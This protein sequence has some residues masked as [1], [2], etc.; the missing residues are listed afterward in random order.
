MPRHRTIRIAAAALVAT[1]AAAGLTGCGDVDAGSAAASAFEELLDGVP[2]VVDVDAS[3]SND[4]PWSGTASA[5]VLIDDAVTADHLGEIVDRIGGF[6]SE[7]SKRSGGATW[8]GVDV[9]VR[10]FTVAVLDRREDNA[11]QLELL[12]SL[13]AEGVPGG[14]LHL[15]PVGADGG[16][17]SSLTLEARPGEDFLDAYDLAGET[18]EATPA[19]ADAVLTGRSDDGDPIGSGADEATNATPGSPEQGEAARFSISS[20]DDDDPTA[21]G[22]P[23]G[24][25]A[26]YLA[27]AEQFAVIG[28]TLT[29]DTLDLRIANVDDVAAASALAT[30]SLPTDVSVEIQGGIVTW[31]D[32]VESP[33]M[34]P[35]VQAVGAVPGVTAID[36]SSDSLRLTVSDPA[37]G[38]AALDTLDTLPAASVVASLRIDGPV[39]AGAPDTF[40]VGGSRAEAAAQFALVEQGLASGSLVSFEGSADRL[41]LEFRNGDDTMLGAAIGLV[42]AG[43][44]P[45]TW[46][47]IEI[48]GEPGTWW[49]D[50]ADTVTIDASAY[51]DETPE[52]TAN[53]ERIERLWNAA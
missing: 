8:E 40:A 50:A 26:A 29:P 23:N 52:E 7:Q 41:Q 33:E 11:T 31:D 43:V 48:E 1:A 34:L 49:F 25:R 10:G 4:L 19:Y 14:E 51:S 22:D 36:A 37:A 3:G 24:S 28:A 45:G 5:S 20:G 21:S 6:L 30:G 46:T 53:R 27:V 15:F 42:K 38:R 13:E 39:A 44:A 18:A 35:V 17:A 32:G 2:D 47:S 12:A 16:R 9:S